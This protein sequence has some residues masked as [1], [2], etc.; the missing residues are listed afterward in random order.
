MRE[1]CREERAI[2][3]VSAAKPDAGCRCVIEIRVRGDRSTVDQRIAQRRLGQ[4]FI[5]VFRRVVVFD[6]RLDRFT[7]GDIPGRGKNL[8]GR[9]FAADRDR[10]GAGHAVVVRRC[11]Q[12]H[13]AGDAGLDQN[14]G[15]GLETVVIVE[16]GQILVIIRVGGE[17]ISRGGDRAVEVEAAADIASNGNRAGVFATRCDAAAECQIAGDAVADV[18]NGR[19]V[20]DDRHRAL[21]PDIAIHAGQNAQTGGVIAAHDQRARIVHIDVADEAASAVDEH[22]DPV[23]ADCR[24]SVQVAEPGI[25]VFAIVDRVA[26]GTDIDRTADRQIARIAADDVHA[27]PA[28]IVADHIDRAI[29][30]DVIIAVQRDGRRGRGERHPAVRRNDD[31][32]GTAAGARRG[33]RDRRRDLVIDLAIG[34]GGRGGDGQRGDSAGKHETATHANS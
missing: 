16:R 27:D 22:A 19:A 31:I 10:R 3:V 29:D 5:L 26:L 2:A 6:G 30:R 34:E 17:A 28:I 7:D 1:F 24:R 8:Q 32:V 25:L 4:A 33:C 12:Q 13:A 18:D 9:R 23:A 14:G 11:V 21:Q 15:P 20:A